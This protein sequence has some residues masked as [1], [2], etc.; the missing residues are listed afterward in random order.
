MKRAEYLLLTVA[1]HSTRKTL[2]QG[3]NQGLR[4]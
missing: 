2:K 1:D 4:I 3:K